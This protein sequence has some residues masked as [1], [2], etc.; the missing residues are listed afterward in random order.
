LLPD[1]ATQILN[2]LIKLTATTE[3]L[4]KV[5]TILLAGRVNNTQNP[6][7]MLRMISN[8]ISAD[9]TVAEGKTD[10]P[11]GEALRAELDAL[12]AGT[13]ELMRRPG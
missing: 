12:M 13:L 1:P 3:V 4:R 5:V 11:G 10:L 7:E 9:I 8:A 2:Q 6:E